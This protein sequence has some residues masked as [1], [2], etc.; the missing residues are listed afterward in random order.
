ML[1]G[2]CT[3]SCIVITAMQLDIVSHKSSACC[4]LRPLLRIATQ[5][6]E[7]DQTV[8]QVSQTKSDCSDVLAS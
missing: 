2:L 5:T 8:I 4:W 6:Q 7:T 1:S 3:Y